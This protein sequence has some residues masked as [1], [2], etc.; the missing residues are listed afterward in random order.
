MY[1]NASEIIRFKMVIFVVSQIIIHHTFQCGLLHMCLKLYVLKYGSWCSCVSTYT[2]YV[3]GVGAHNH[4]SRI[5][6][7]AFKDGCFYW[8]S[9][10]T[11]YILR[12][13]VLMCLELY[14][15]PLKVVGSVVSQIIHWTQFFLFKVYSFVMIHFLKLSAIC[16]PRAEFFLALM[17]C[18]RTGFLED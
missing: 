4:M 8:V 17:P 10:Y 14:I 1:K 6:H 7:D 15:I 5:I 9:N 13:L 3:L 2:L 11:L 12:K 16:F 18:R